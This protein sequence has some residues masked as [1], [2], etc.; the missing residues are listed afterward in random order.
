MVCAKEL[1]DVQTA[2]QAADMVLKARP[3]YG[4]AQ[5]A[6]QA[7]HDWA[8]RKGRAEAIKG[9][10]GLLKSKIHRIEALQNMNGL[11]GLEEFGLAS[12]ERSISDARPLNDG[13]SGRLEVGEHRPSVAIYCGGC[14]EDWGPKTPDGIGGSEQ[15]VRDLTPEL[16]KLDLN[17]T[18]YAPVPRDERGL[19]KNV[20]WR[21]HLEFNDSLPRDYFVAW[22]NAG[23]LQFPVPAKKRYLWL[24]DIGGNGIWKDPTIRALCN[25]AIF[26]SPWHRDYNS[27]CPEEKSFTSRNSVDVPLIEQ[28][29][30]D[31]KLPKRNP[32]R[33]V[34]SSSPDRQLHRVLFAWQQAQEE[35]WLPAEAEL[36]VLYGFNACYM[37]MADRAPYINVKGRE[38][39][40]MDY[41]EDM[42]SLMDQLPGVSYGGRMPKRGVLGTFL[43][44]GAML[45]TPSF[46]ETYC[47]SAA[48]AQACGCIPLTTDVA[49]LKTTNRHGTQCTDSGDE[50]AAYELL[51]DYVECHKTA[52]NDEVRASIAAQ[53]REAFSTEALAKE[54][55]EEL[56][57]GK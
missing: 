14:W 7:L 33:F 22:R 34:Y 47:I 46:T 20:T 8:N 17:V 48:E 21:H 13:G 6:R 2:L 28:V 36:I 40:R 42:I 9:V 41:M 37:G 23:F 27:D 53:S 30:K 50:E 15:M 39:S 25:K 56:F 10:V 16:A 19:H 52:W 11:E 24:H 54:W 49:A 3:D 45:Y 4:F 35:G 31:P 5:G 55:K 29:E 1:G 12:P 38:R 18:V 26:L 44:S 57:N 51:K 32:L 43:C